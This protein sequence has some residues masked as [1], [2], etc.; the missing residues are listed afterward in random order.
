MCLATRSEVHKMVASETTGNYVC[1]G[2]IVGALASWEAEEPGVIEKVAQ[3]ARSLDVE[4]PP[5]VTP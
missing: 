2:C 4:K 5:E 1:S 3:A